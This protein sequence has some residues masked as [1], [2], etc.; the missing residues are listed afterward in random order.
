MGGV[1]CCVTIR[2]ST[3]FLCRPL[4]SAVVFQIQEIMDASHH[5]LKRDPSLKRNDSAG[6]NLQN[7]SQHVIP[8]VCMVQARACV[9][10]VARGACV[11]PTVRVAH[12]WR[13]HGALTP[14]C[15]RRFH[16]DVIDAALVRVK[17]RGACVETTAPNLMP[18]R[19]VAQTQSPWL[20]RPSLSVKEFLV[21]SAT[22]LCVQ[23]GKK[24]KSSFV[25][26]AMQHALPF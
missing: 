21:Q 19:H 7:K 26:V 18:L 4:T 12:A 16:T 14:Y 1:T 15:P 10:T 3:C 13:K 24:R 11:I 23:D 17:L 2:L 5:P 9:F 8:T 6:S 22:D 20:G 25:Q